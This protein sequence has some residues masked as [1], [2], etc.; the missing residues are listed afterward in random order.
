[1]KNYRYE[2]F[3]KSHENNDQRSIFIFLHHKVFNKSLVKT[4]KIVNCEMNFKNLYSKATVFHKVLDK[5]LV[6]IIITEQAFFSHFALY[7]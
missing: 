3:D 2:V 5:S 1:M 4:D 6:K 7:Q